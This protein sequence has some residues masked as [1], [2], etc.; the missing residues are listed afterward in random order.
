MSTFTR[1]C[2]L[3]HFDLDLL[4]TGQITAGNTETSGCNLFDCG[5]TV[6]S[7]RSDGQTILVLTTF[8]GV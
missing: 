1:L 8:T 3:C 2:S 6:L 7:V 5:T 4:R